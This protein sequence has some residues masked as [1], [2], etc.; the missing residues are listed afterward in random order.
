MPCQ[1]F[2]EVETWQS[3]YIDAT[4]LLIITKNATILSK[5]V[6]AIFAFDTKYLYYN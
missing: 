2:S 6:I 1:V 3:S 5:K 4:I